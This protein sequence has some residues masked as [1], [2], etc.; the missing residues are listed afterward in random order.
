MSRWLKLT[1]RSFV[2]TDKAC[3]ISVTLTDKYTL[4]FMFSSHTIMMDS[5]SDEHI[6]ILY[7]YVFWEAEG[8]NVFFFYLFIFNSRSHVGYSTYI[9]KSMNNLAIRCYGF[10]FGQ[11]PCHPFSS[12]ISGTCN[13]KACC[14]RGIVT[15]IFSESLSSFGLLI[16]RNVIKLVFAAK[17]VSG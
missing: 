17:N 14:C 7:K 11:I 9:M 16:P 4:N 5:Q 2:I 15:W 1:R 8:V 13:S 3:Q 6:I 10:Q 12:Q